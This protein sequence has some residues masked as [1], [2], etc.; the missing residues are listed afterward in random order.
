MCVHLAGSGAMELMSRE[1]TGQTLWAVQ[2]RPG[3]RQQYPKRAAHKARHGAGARQDSKRGASV[4]QG[5][6]GSS[7]T[8]RGWGG[9]WLCRLSVV[10]AIW[11]LSFPNSLP[12]R[13]VPCG[14]RG[15]LPGGTLVSKLPWGGWWQHPFPMEA[16]DMGFPDALP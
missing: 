14:D 9:K 1:M 5:G 2:E 12:L 3:E 11:A 16:S 8:A 15:H 10:P 4:G 6:G 13:I 7:E